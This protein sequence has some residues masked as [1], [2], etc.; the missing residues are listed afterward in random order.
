MSI[1][2][3]STSLSAYSK[4]NSTCD[5]H[6]YKYKMKNSTET[7]FKKTMKASFNGAWKEKD[8]NAHV[9]TSIVDG[10][11]QSLMKPMM[12]NIID[13]LY[14]E[15]YLSSSE[16]TTWINHYNSLDNHE[17]KPDSDNWFNKDNWWRLYWKHG[18]KDKIRDLSNKEISCKR[19]GLFKIDGV[20]DTRDTATVGACCHEKEKHHGKDPSTSPFGLFGSNEDE[21]RYALPWAGFDKKVHFSS[22]KQSCVDQG[23][24][25][26]SHTECC[27]SQC[28]KGDISNADE[29]GT[30]APVLA[31]YKLLSYG[32]DCHPMNNPYC[33]STANIA[34]KVPPLYNVY[35]PLPT[36]VGC[37][38]INYEGTGIGECKYVN[39]QCSA[40]TECC[41][42]RC[43]NGKCEEQYRCLACLKN[44]ERLS[45]VHPVHRGEYNGDTQ[46]KKDY[47]PNKIYCCPGFWADPAD[48]DQTCQPVFPPLVLPSLDGSSA[49]VPKKINK[50]NL[51]WSAVG[52]IVDFIIPSA[53]A[54][55]S[56]NYYTEEQHTQIENQINTC[57]ATHTND[58]EE[59][60][61]CMES[62]NTLKAG[63]REENYSKAQEDLEEKL[64]ECT[65]DHSGDE[66]AYDECVKN[67]NSV[68]HA[69]CEQLSTQ[70][71]VNSYNL[72]QITTKTY[73]DPET[74]RFNSLN[75]NW[76][77]AS[78]YERNAE[79]V[80]R[81]FEYVFSGQ[82]SKD[83]WVQEGQGKNIYERSKHIAK[84]VGEKR[85]ELIKKMKEMDTTLLCKCVKAKGGKGVPADVLAIFNTIPECEADKAAL[86]AIQNLS[87]GGGSAEVS[88]FGAS[89]LTGSEYLATY[90]Q[91][92]MEVQMD[93][94]GYYAELEEDLAELSE[95]I[96]TVDWY[97]AD[98]GVE[99]LYTFKVRWMTTWGYI[100]FILVGAVLVVFAAPYAAIGVVALAG[101]SSA[102]VTAA[103]TIGAIIAL[104]GIGTIIASVT[105]M[106][107]SAINNANFKPT[108]RDISIKP[109]HEKVWDSDK[110]KWKWSEG[111]CWS[112]ICFFKYFKIQ[113]YYD[114]P[115]FN[116]SKYGATGANVCDIKAGANLCMRSVYMT[117]FENDL[118][119]L[120]DVKK[121]LFVA[122]DAYSEDTNFIPQFNGAFTYL[123][124]HLKSTNPGG[125]TNKKFLLRDILSEPDT[126]KAMMPLAGAY[127]PAPFD[128]SKELAVLNA[129]KTFSACKEINP[130]GDSTQENSL[131][132]PEQCKVSTEGYDLPEEYMGYGNFF[133][134]QQDID[135]FAAYVYQHHFHWPSLS[136]SQ[137]MGYPLLAQ[138]AYYQ[139]ILHN[140]RI[141]GSSAASR[142]IGY[143]DAYDAYAAD[144][145]ARAADYDCTPTDV[146][147]NK[148][149]SN[150]A[151][152]AVISSGLNASNVKYSQDFRSKFKSLNF[153]MATSSVASGTS[154]S[155]ISIGSGNFSEGE[156]NLLDLGNK[157]AMRTQASLEKKKRFDS[158]VSTTAR[159]KLVNSAAK[160]WN[161]AFGSPMN[162]MKMTKGGQDYGGKG[163]RIGAKSTTINNVNNSSAGAGGKGFDLNQFKNSFK[164]N[165][166]SS[167]R[168]GGSSYGSSSSSS[169]TPKKTA[170]DNSS[171]KNYSNLLDMASKN[172][173]MF[174]RDDSDS[175]FTIISK[176]YF[177]NL[178][179]ILKRNESE[180][181]KKKEDDV[182]EPKMKKLKGSKKDELKK[183]LGK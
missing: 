65:T 27:S 137:E 7:D 147:G 38:R 157:H 160:N 93:R 166:G 168:G 132:D 140:L 164:Y 119:Y 100:F 33:K 86:D 107:I 81:G 105:G 138:N 99:E 158:V 3:F 72:P 123:I 113:R 154:K 47:D 8:K 153:N 61:K 50:P 89:G 25:C 28:M 84:T 43:S 92:R 49:K 159:G 52:K 126:Q 22:A 97:E 177:R 10:K 44:N 13:Q 5:V 19:T 18:F 125:L 102:A 145:S 34:R 122:S 110:K 2:L 78:N 108:I 85:V 149:E 69:T 4:C 54:I 41:S 73:S 48:E 131:I 16:K 120:I 143:G 141:I 101:W 150:Q 180:G 40:S 30:C 21:F 162:K 169:Y 71:Y 36:R 115:K 96:Q 23:G 29:K 59:R 75:D 172:Q 175:I 109:K 90:A 31:C 56:C 155:D 39:T 79:I 112:W 76:K 103:L 134:T 106:I 128:E 68:V 51:F 133:E 156:T 32:S 17:K 151:V 62:I 167:R 121:P 55:D 114:Y 118:R 127:Y 165:A 161:N 139:T 12:M 104:G 20:N 80:I 15:G 58:V 178:S 82:G 45:D 179:L 1:I 111:K 144:Y 171:S 74:C 116:N 117:T 64:Q 130:S 88:A 98:Q 173:K 63:Y 87:D 136:A 135:D 124:Q 24:E 37:L 176:T 146:K 77:D 94:F 9:V 70:D 6:G 183:L 67:A 170:G 11:E 46:E 91:E 148:I 152:C 35:L 57:L 66:A 26:S 42:G 83:Y 163:V 53:H 129:I 174:K 182:Y 14:T 60:N 95:Y 181:E 142:G